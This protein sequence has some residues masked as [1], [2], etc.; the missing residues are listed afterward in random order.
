MSDCTTVS[1]G[2]PVYNGEQT[3]RFAIESLLS[4]THGDFVLQVSDNGSTDGTPDLLHEYSRQDSRVE[5]SSLKQNIGAVANFKSL[6]QQSDG[7]YFMW[8]A[9]DDRW[10]RDFLAKG[11]SILDENPDVGF[12]FPTFKLA[13]QLLPLQ[14]KVAP[15]TFS[16]V[17]DLDRR[18]RV[19]KFANLHPLSHKCNLVYSLFRREM[20]VDACAKQDLNDDGLL[21]MVILSMGRGKLIDSHSFV[22]CYRLFW[23]GMFPVLEAEQCS[24]SNDLHLRHSN[25]DCSQFLFSAPEQAASIVVLVTLSRMN[26]EFMRRGD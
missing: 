13:S 4:Q 9:C 1:I 15:E 6:L 18:V 21:S 8:A 5:V 12:A 3:I 19:M 14:K 22:K 2:L 17:E 26:M 16:M 10:E 20:L 11:A 23:P 7:K 25:P 24:R